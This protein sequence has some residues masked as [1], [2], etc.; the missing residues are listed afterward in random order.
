MLPPLM[1]MVPATP[2]VPGLAGACSRPLVPTVRVD[3]VPVMVSRLP[4]GQR[5]AIQVE[6]RRAAVQR[7]RHVHAGA[8]R[9]CGRRGAADADIGIAGDAE[10]GAGPVQGQRAVSGLQPAQRIDAAAQFEGLGNRRVG[11][12]T[13]GGGDADP[14]ADGQQRAARRADQQAGCW[15]SGPPETVDGAA[16]SSSPAPTRPSVSSMLPPVMIRLPSS[17]AGGPLKPVTSSV[18]S[19]DHGSRY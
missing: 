1:A 19:G 17:A 3:V 2:I 12:E 15:T 7:A 18:V 16:F 4:D 14:V 6:Y 8:G 5:A 9:D 10:V 11:G 13:A